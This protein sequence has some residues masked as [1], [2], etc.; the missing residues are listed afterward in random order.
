MP[1]DIGLF[2]VFVFFFLLLFACLFLWV[3]FTFTAVWDTNNSASVKVLSS[4]SCCQLYLRVIKFWIY[5]GEYHMFS[6]CTEIDFAWD[7][8]PNNCTPLYFDR[9]NSKGIMKPSWWLYVEAINKYLVLLMH[10]SPVAE[11]VYI[12]L[13]CLY[14]IQASHS[15]ISLELYLVYNFYVENLELGMY[16]SIPVFCMPV[17]CMEWIYLFITIHL[18]ST[19]AI[20]FLFALLIMK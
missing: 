2:F 16:F 20:K 14:K 4:S 17:F 7:H 11:G 3:M 19:N 13:S 15:E 8:Y 1:W 5:L 18:K 12:S 6:K 9:M 10:P